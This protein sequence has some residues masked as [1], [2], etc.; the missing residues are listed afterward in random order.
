MVSR[1]LFN[2]GYGAGASGVSADYKR[3]DPEAW[4]QGR[5]PAGMVAG[6]SCRV[7]GCPR[8]QPKIGAFEFSSPRCRDHGAMN[9]DCYTAPREH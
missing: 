7:P 2:H 3:D 9:Q 1:A 6:W 4:T 8:R 5:A